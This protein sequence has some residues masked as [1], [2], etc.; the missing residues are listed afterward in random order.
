VLELK[1]PTTPAPETQ[2]QLD[3]GEAHDFSV[4]VGQFVGI[5]V[6][7]E[8]VVAS[9]YAFA[10]GDPTEWLSVCNTRILLGTLHLRTGHRLFSNRRR[11]L[12]VWVHDSGR[13]HDLLLPPCVLLGATAHTRSPA[14][15]RLDDTLTRIGG[16]P[17]YKPDPLNLFLD[18]RIDAAG[19]IVVHSPEAG[20]HAALRATTD[21]GCVILAWSLTEARASAD[22]ALAVTIANRWSRS[23]PII[24]G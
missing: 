5:K 9:L 23:E 6:V 11:T 15:E 18:T 1:A 7:S 19:R 14:L 21:L 16:D 2:F 24:S 20:A 12:L 8:P 22:P 4:K 13:G 3:I 17:T 10:K